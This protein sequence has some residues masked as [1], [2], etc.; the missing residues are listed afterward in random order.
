MLI[1]SGSMWRDFLN[2]GYLSFEYS[3]GCKVNDGNWE[4]LFELVL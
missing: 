3:N 2:I 4:A 1:N